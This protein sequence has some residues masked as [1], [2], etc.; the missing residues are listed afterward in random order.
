MSK[1]SNGVDA[2]SRLF[3]SP[4][5][6]KL[7]RLFLFNE[8]LAFSV[9]DIAKRAKVGKEAVRKEVATLLASGIIKKRSQKG[10]IEFQAN[11]KWKHFDAL[12]AFLRSSGDINDENVLGN[13]KKA[14][15]LRLVAL[16]GLFTGV[17]ESKVDILVVGDKIADGLLSRGVHTLEAELGRELRYAA[18]S[19]EDFK[20]RVGVYDRLVRDVFDYPHRL[21]FDRLSAP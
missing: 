9:S 17:P 11:R 2:L 6:V 20:Y 8:E 21:I 16:S 4:N 10:K 7:L 1:T 3:G 15:T 19:T 14:G 13:L 5:R 18:F 12:F